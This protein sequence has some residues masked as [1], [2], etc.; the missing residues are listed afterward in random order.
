MKEIL[1]VQNESFKYWKS[2]TKSKGLRE[3]KHFLLS[4]SKI[5]NELINADINSNQ[6]NSSINH[7]RIKP[8][9][10]S[11]QFIL[12]FDGYQSTNSL[13]TNLDP[14]SWIRL[15]RDLFDQIDVLGTKHPILVLEQPTLVDWTQDLPPHGLEVL[16]PCGD[17]QNLGAIS[18]NMIAFGANLLVILKECAH[19]FL[20]KTIKASSGAILRVP[21]ALGPSIDEINSHTTAIDLNGIPLDTA[22]LKPHWRI[23]FGEEGQGVPNTFKGPKITIPMQNSMESLNAAVA[24]GIIL[25]QWQRQQTT[26]NL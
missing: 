7:F 15:P 25:Y 19:P 26:N 12:T 9:N 20:P 11:L 14:T 21:I 1:S 18:R 3:G 10:Q 23:L 2:L 16:C 6:L 5:I 8:L 17:P 22:S 4:G 24:S 13:L